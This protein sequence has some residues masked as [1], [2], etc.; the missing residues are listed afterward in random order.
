MPVYDLVPQTP[1]RKNPTLRALVGSL[2]RQADKWESLPNGW[3]DE[4]VEKFWD[5]LTGDAKHKVTKCM[6]KMDGK[7]DDTGAFCASLADKIEGGTDWRGKKA[8]IHVTV[9]ELPAPLQKV[10]REVRYNRK[11]IGVETSTTYDPGGAGGNGYRAFTAAVNLETGQYKI[12]WGSWGGANIFTQ[13]QVDL[14]TSSRPIP[15]NGAVVKGE[16]GG[17]GPVY[18][19]ILI[20]PANLAKLLPAPAEALDLSPEE[21]K[22]LR[23]ISE[24]RGGVR[25]GAFEYRGLGAYGPNN[26]HIQ[27][28]AQKGLVKV[29]GS[30]IMITLTGKNAM[31]QYRGQHRFARSTMFLTRQDLKNLPPLYSQEENKDPTVWVKF[32][33]PY[34]SGT[35]LATEFDGKDIF[36]GAVDLGHGWELGYFSL[37]EMKSIQATIGGRKMPFQG[38]ERDRYFRPAPLSR[39]KHAAMKQQV[40]ARWIS[41]PRTASPLQDLVDAFADANPGEE[42]PDAMEVRRLHY[43][44]PV[45]MTLSQWMA[46]MMAAAP[47]YNNFDAVRVGRHL[48]RIPGI[49]KVKFQP[50]REGNPAV[51]LA[52]PLEPLTLIRKTKRALRADDADFEAGGELRLWWD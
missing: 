31:E 39:S 12:L 37:S 45:W 27:S 44:S 3:T 4:S 15:P 6:E 22:A 38:I 2:L 42:R 48:A 47:E 51:Y 40:V 50:G 34:G 29:M 32:F 33:N 46:A 5:T 20:G 49:G 1:S 18:A 25:S 28:L 10:L 21:I 36:F 11:D 13:N 23:I 19:H 52:G 14:D 17:T 41:K 26:P 7:I 43:K 30:G 35:W 24:I 9:R 8:N 16:I